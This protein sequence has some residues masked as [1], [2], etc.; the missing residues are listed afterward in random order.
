MRLSALRRI[1]CACIVA[2]GVLAPAAAEDGSASGAVVLGWRFV[3]VDGAE[4]KYRQHINLDEGARVFAIDFDYRPLSGFA[5]LLELNVDSLGGEPYESVDFRMRK[6]GEYDFQFGRRKSD[7]FYEDLLLPAELVN[8]R[9]SNGGDFHHFDFERVRDFVSLQLTLNPRAKLDVALDRFSKDGDRTTVFDVS[10]DEFELDQPIDE[11]MDQ[12]SVGFQYRWPKTTVVLRETYRD[13]ENAREIFLP[14]QSAG[15]NAGPAILDFYF[16]DQ[17]INFTSNRHTAQVN[18]RPHDDVIVRVAAT[19]E[20]LDLDTAVSERAQGIA[21]NGAPLAF[22]LSGSGE[23]ARDLELFDVDVSWLLTD[24][25]AVIGGVRQYNLDQDGLLPY[26]GEAGDRGWEI[27]TTSIDLG[28]E[29]AATE[30]ITV[31]FGLREENRDV[32]ERIGGDAVSESTDHTG[33]FAT[34]Q[35]RPSKQLKVGLNYEESSY[36]DPYTLA[37]PTDRDRLRL[38]MRYNH[39]GSGAFAHGV[40]LSQDVEN[41]NSAWQADYDSLSVRGGYRKNGLEISA[42]YSFIDVERQVDQVLTT[43]GFGGGAMIDFPVLFI[44]EAD[45]LDGRVAWSASSRLRLGVDVRF[46]ENE[47]GFGTERDDLRTFAEVGLTNAYMLR[48]SYRTLDYGETRF[49]LNDYE[50]DILELGL[51]Y[52]F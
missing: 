35:W 33:Y 17:P 14:G 22:D 39:Q 24:R 16:L 44:S 3:D 18:S 46:Y 29:V 28:L 40:Y 36:D 30:E 48:V 42:G 27:D 43:V 19:L 49:G 10:R 21:F 31:S 2:A 26:N 15:E 23:S 8:P 45:F 9:V 4:G 37:S 47:G 41:S 25:F 5:D 6:F 11:T 51:G 7:Y 13:Y 50:A 52:R 1:G 32:D 38:S 34:V 20:S 12:V